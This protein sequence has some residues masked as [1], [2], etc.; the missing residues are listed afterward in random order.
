MV[1]VYRMHPL[2]LADHEAHGL[3]DPG[4]ACPNILCREFRRA[5][6]IQEAFTPQALAREAR[7]WL[8]DA[9][10]CRAACSAASPS[11]TQTLRRDTGALRHRG[12]RP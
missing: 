10:R 8:D 3:P 7:A 5:E 2:E 12:D 4:W 1:I 6:L 11:C 9:P